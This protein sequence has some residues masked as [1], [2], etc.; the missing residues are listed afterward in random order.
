MDSDVEFINYSTGD[1]HT[2]FVKMLT[3][4]SWLLQ[5]S[6]HCAVVREIRKTLTAVIPYAP[7]LRVQPETVLILP[8]HP[9]DPDCGYTLIK[10]CDCGINPKH[11]DFRFA[12]VL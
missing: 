3:I 6:V 8:R 7:R 11:R 5:Y 9:K 1:S 2:A 10:H 12:R 4:Y